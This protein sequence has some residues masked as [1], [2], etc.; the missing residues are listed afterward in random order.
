MKLDE[1]RQADHIF[2]KKF[3]PNLTFSHLNEKSEPIVILKRDCLRESAPYSFI[4]SIGFTTLPLDLDM[5]YPSGPS[6]CPLM[7]I[8]SNGDESVMMKQRK[9]V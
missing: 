1:K 9:I 3:L 4:P 6:I 5:L 7:I 2:C 8:S